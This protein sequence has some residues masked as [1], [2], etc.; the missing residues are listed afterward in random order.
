MHVRLRWMSLWLVLALPLLAVGTSTRAQAPAT[1]P[2][3]RVD[4]NLMTL[5]VIPRTSSG[6]FVSDLRKEEFEVVDGGEPQDVA[7]IVLVHGGRVFNVLQPAATSE[8][9]PEG[10]I[11][12]KATRS[13]PTAGRVF[14]IL[15]DD[16]H[17]TATDT[18]F[19]RALLKKIASTLLHPG[20]MFAVFSTGPSSIE[21]PM[22][23][24]LSR[25][26]QAIGQVQGR[27]M[28]YRDVMDSRDGAQG[29]QGLRQNAHVAF[30]TAYAMVNGLE[31][32]RDRRKAVILISNGYDFDPFPQGRA[33]TDQVFGGRYGTPWADPERGERFMGLGQQSNRFADADLSSELAALAGAANRVNAAFHTIDPRGLV[34][35][36]SVADQV[37][38][39]EMR[40]HIGKTT[41]SLRLL[42]EAT[43]GIA[44]VNDNDL[45]GALKRI[46]A[47][48]SDYYILG[49]YLSNPDPK[50][51]TRTVDVKVRRPGV[52]VRARGWYQTKPPP[53]SSPQR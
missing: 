47:E 44:V 29:P 34:T 46:D 41:S 18:P 36:T 19:V 1:Q 33:G 23:Y 38:P 16:L 13:D 32:V 42:A 24:D 17:F 39:T 37:D 15:I 3:F 9:A 5:D 40:S 31:R 43:G 21:I 12:P 48:T 35:I 14:V 20:D 27:G 26:T 4:V 50:R 8:P 52:E 10:I 49:Y 7:S 28:S 51:R 6:Q 11:L 45:D 53:P 22:S 2:T 30:S 25:L